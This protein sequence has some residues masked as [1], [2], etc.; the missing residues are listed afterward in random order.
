MGLKH[1]IW[2]IYCKIHRHKQVKITKKCLLTVCF[3]LTLSVGAFCRSSLLVACDPNM[4]QAYKSELLTDLTK[5]KTDIG[6][7]QFTSGIF[8]LLMVFKVN[9]CLQDPLTNG[10]TEFILFDMLSDN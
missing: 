2:E 3:F 1:K 6:T 9:L 8:F 4:A 7:K 10:S 5:I